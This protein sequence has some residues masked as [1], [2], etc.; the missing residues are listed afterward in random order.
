MRAGTP[1]EN[2][3]DLDRDGDFDLGLD[4]DFDLDRDGEFGLG[5]NGDFVL[6][7]DKRRWSLST[8]VKLPRGTP[9]PF[10]ACEWAWCVHSDRRFVNAPELQIC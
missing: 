7:L 4:R 2:D 5:C 8:R 10:P 6:G 1:A 9:S 3:L